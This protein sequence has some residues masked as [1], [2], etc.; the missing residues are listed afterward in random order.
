M[1][2]S[3]PVRHE[4]QVGCPVDHAF[5]VFTARVDA[6]W[7]VAHRTRP[8]AVLTL[9]GRVGGRLLERGPDGTEAPLGTILVWDPP[10]AVGFTWR[11]G[12]PP[13]RFTRVDVRFVAEGEARTRV[14]VV[15]VEGDSGLGAQWPE[16][17]RRFDENW[18]QVLAAYV[19]A[20]ATPAGRVR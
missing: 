4:V 11:L 15:H 9:E 16:R 18:G 12:A 14:E 5:E 7:P 10:R 6:W 17:A 13:G 19:R 8:G 20:V 1:S 3:A 2:E